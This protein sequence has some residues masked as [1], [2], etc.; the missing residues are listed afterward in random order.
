MT[1]GLVTPKDLYMVFICGADLLLRLNTVTCRFS[2]GRL[3]AYFVISPGRCI[4]MNEMVSLKKSK[5]V[6]VNP[7][8]GLQ[9][10]NTL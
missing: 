2:R 7:L 4:E 5:N 1:M 3:S 9:G 10:I 8:P 6:N